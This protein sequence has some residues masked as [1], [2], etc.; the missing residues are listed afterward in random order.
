MAD[1][2][3]NGNFSVYLDDQN[4]IA[5]VNGRDAFE[6]EVVIKITDYLYAETIGDVSL[7]NL[8]SAVKLQIS[9]VANDFDE[10]ESIESVDISRTGQGTLETTIIYDTGEPLTFEVDT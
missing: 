4:D 6:Q 9:R 10:I 2:G 8:K 5:Y 3:L 7:T 1:I